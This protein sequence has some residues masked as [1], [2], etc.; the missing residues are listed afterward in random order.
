MP[1][2]FKTASEWQLMKKTKNVLVASD[3]EAHERK[4]LLNLIYRQ[5]KE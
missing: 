4:N 2:V 1:R 3:I 5:V